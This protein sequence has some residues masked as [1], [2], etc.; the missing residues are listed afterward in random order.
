MKRNSTQTLVLRMTGVVMLA[1]GAGRD[2]ETACGK[3]P[4]EQIGRA[5]V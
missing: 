5:H 1:I 4:S 2:S 3:N